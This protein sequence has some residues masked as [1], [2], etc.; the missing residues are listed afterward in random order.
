MLGSIAVKGFPSQRDSDEYESALGFFCLVRLACPM[1]MFGG[2]MN[3]QPNSP[4]PSTFPFLAALSYPILVE[5]PPSHA[6]NS[7]RH[8]TS[9]AR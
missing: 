2:K 9:C 7:Q 3:F 8:E 6:K 1:A 4:S 5:L